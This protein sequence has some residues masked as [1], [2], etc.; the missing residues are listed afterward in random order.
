LIEI[1]VWPP[2]TRGMILY[3]DICSIKGLLGEYFSQ[4]LPAN[5]IVG[6]LKIELQQ[7]AGSFVELI[8]SMIY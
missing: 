6:F 5:S 1:D 3:M 7:T 4:E 2:L 8:S